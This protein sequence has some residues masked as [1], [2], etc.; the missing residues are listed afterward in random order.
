MS[1]IEVIPAYECDETGMVLGYRFT[2]RLAS[3]VSFCSRLSYCDAF[4]RFTDYVDFIYH[5]TDG[6]LA[7]AVS[8]GISRIIEYASVDQ[9]ERQR[10][11]MV[12][13]Y[14]AASRMVSE[15]Y[16]IDE[17]WVFDWLAD[18]VGEYL[19]EG[20]E[21]EAAFGYTMATLVVGDF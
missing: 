5:D 17:G 14:D 8:R 11:H 18:L 9:H 3:M 21:F 10:D 1:T 16:G 13:M 19:D 6:D 15:S 20:E 12:L 4:D 2:D 7:S